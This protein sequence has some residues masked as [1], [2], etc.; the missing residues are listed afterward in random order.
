MTVT[1][2]AD[3][4][5]DM[6]KI[7]VSL[8]LAVPFSFAYA[9]E[10]MPQGNRRGCQG[11]VVNRIVDDTAREQRRMLFESYEYDGEE[12]VATDWDGSYSNGNDARDPEG[13]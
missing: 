3:Y 10:R 13:F 1:H 9:D 6:P 12:R 5:G 8:L 7:I 2:P 4:T 11:R